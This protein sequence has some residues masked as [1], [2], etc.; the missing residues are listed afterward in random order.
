MSGDISLL[1]LNF[2]DGNPNI[3]ELNSMYIVLVPKGNF[4]LYQFKLKLATQKHSKMNIENLELLRRSSGWLPPS[5]YLM[6]P[7]E[8]FY[9]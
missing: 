6:S 5:K 7:K 4:G 2:L 3:D 1:I 8:N 9:R